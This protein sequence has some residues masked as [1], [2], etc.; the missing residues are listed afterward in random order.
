[1]NISTHLWF[2]N[3]SYPLNGLMMT[4][5]STSKGTS[6]LPPNILVI[7]SGYNLN[8]LNILVFP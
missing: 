6:S 7:P 4:D 3:C 8:T 5:I 2:K 1:M